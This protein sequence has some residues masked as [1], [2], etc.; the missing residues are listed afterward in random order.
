MEKQHPRRYRRKKWM[1]ESGSRQRLRWDGRQWA[2]SKTGWRESRWWGPSVARMTD[3]AVCLTGA[4]RPGMAAV[5]WSSK[6]EPGLGCQIWPESHD[7]RGHGCFRSGW[8]ADSGRGSGRRGAAR[9]VRQCGGD[10]PAAECHGWLAHRWTTQW[11][12]RW[13]V[14]SNRDAP[15]WAE[16]HRWTDLYGLKNWRT[17]L[18]PW[19]KAVDRDGRRGWRTGDWSMNDGGQ[20]RRGRSVWIGWLGL[21]WVGPCMG[22]RTAQRAWEPLFCFHLLLRKKKKR[23]RKKRDKLNNKK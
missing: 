22:W 6:P 20:W 7:W 5:A 12:A 1:A 15:V 19:V 3:G 9:W 11:P 14:V 2:E 21:N 23:K 8:L 16:Q 10:G 4:S 13:L 17:W 18:L